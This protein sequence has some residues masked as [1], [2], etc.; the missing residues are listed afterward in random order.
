MPA[1]IEDGKDQISERVVIYRVPPGPYNDPENTRRVRIQLDG[2][3]AEAM[4]AGASL[5]F[6]RNGHFGH[7]V[8]SE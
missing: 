3:V 5:Y 7:L 4:E 2:I 1:V 6:W 8:I